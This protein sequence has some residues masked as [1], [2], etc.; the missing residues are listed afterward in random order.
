MASIGVKLGLIGLGTVGTGVVQLLTQNHDNI[1]R[2]LGRPLSLVRAASR[3]IATKPHPDLGS[4]QVS[5]DP[6]SVVEDPKVDLVIELIGGIEPAR[7]LV[8]EALKRGKA[9]VTANKAL[10]AQHGDEIFATAEEHEVSVG[11]EA[12]A[13]GGIPIIRTL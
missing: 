7:T 11:F 6:W 3:S 2:K 4:A 1:A 10:L 12:S 5:T 8:L 9:V 13:A